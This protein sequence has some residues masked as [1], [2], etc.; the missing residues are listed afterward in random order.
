MYLSKV[1]FEQV[2]FRNDLGTTPYLQFTKGFLSAVPL[3]LVLWPAL[4]GGCYAFTRH[5]ERLAKA[6]AKKLKELQAKK[7]E[8]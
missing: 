5:R 8:K 4:L 3:V 1:P 6:E 2:A 7:E